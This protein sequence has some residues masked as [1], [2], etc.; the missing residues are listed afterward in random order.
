MTADL[1][2]VLCS[3]AL[4]AGSGRFPWELSVR[5]KSVATSLSGV[6]YNLGLS[7]QLSNCTL[8]LALAVDSH[9]STPWTTSGWRDSSID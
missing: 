1:T 4:E 2:L 5:R 8:P 3:D 7:T 6:E 9:S